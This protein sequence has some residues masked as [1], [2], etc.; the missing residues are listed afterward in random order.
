MNRLF[1]AMSTNNARTEN[2]MP[3]HSTSGS[4]LV[5]FFG[6]A[7]S[8]RN[9]E[10]S[11][12]RRYFMSAFNVNRNYALKLLFWARDIR[13]GA[14]ERKL[15]RDTIEHLADT[16]PDELGRNVRFIPE[17]GRWDDVLVLFGTSLE[18][19]ALRLI[20]D[21][22]RNGDGLCAKWMPRKGANANKIRAY[23]QVTPKFYRQTLVKLTNVVEQLMCSKEFEAI[24]Y[25]K[26][27]SL[28]MARLQK[29]FERNDPLGF[30]KYIESL[31]KGEVKINAG[32]VYPYDVIKSLQSGN[33]DI[34]NAQ[35]LALPDYLEG[36]EGKSILPV[37]D[38][39][40]S[41]GMTV[42]GKTST[43]C[44]D[45]AISLGLYLS[46]RNRGP[47]KDHFMTFS[48]KPQLQEVRGS[49]YDKYTSMRHAD[50]G[51]N[52]N[53]EAVFEIILSKAK[54]SRLS[55]VDMPDQILIISDM[56]FDQCTRKESGYYS[57]RYRH[58]DTGWDMNALKMIKHKYLLAGYKLPEII[59]WNL[60]AVSGQS[61]VKV[62]DTGVALV[63]GF[64][65]AIMKSILSASEIVAEKELTPVDVMMEV[66]D[67]DR[68]A[69]VG[70]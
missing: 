41:M 16:Y 59:F 13:G 8:A 7:G 2:N 58:E 48:G 22:L 3:T 21:A 69:Q 37:V 19:K 36:S 65:P 28:A 18:N 32:A 47:F 42:G 20:A 54:A 57:S 45:V 39:S 26:L 31:K 53:I 64:S 70:I 52:T 50:W 44:M 62:N 61:P 43:T 35:W 17:Y 60:R 4:S 15:F 34:A 55:E 23:L 68:Y 1:N 56:Q 38:V 49:L 66:I 33:R 29:A 67:S 46:E 6:I 63:S 25:S 12:T 5:D 10:V 11:E 24:D 51:F 40:G 14:G 30:S 9:M 27:P